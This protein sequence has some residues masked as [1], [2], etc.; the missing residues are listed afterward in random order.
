MIKKRSIIR[1]LPVAFLILNSQVALAQ[2][3][4]GTAV[5]QLQNYVAQVNAAAN[6]E[7]YQGIPFRC[8]GNPICMQSLLG[9][10]NAWYMQ[11][12]M[13]VN[14]WY[15][16]ITMQCT[17]GGTQNIPSRRPSEEAPGELDE[18]AIEDLEIDDEDKS[19]RIRI[20]STPRGYR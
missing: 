16:Q 12:S 9:Q 5:W 11:Q 19:V 14:S 7:Y 17:G 10:L 18:G 13:Q 8:G 2:N 20:P 1:C 6:A 3:T 15:G 4:C